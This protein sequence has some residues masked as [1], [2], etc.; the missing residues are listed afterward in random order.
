M[1]QIRLIIH[2]DTAE[3]EYLNACARIRNISLSALVRRLVRAAANDQMVSAILDD[4]GART[5]RRGEHP[6][7]NS[8]PRLSGPER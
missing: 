8:A 5:R 3:G 6:P 2:P 7:R 1:T 4:G